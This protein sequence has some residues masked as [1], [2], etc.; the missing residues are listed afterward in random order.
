MITTFT[1]RSLM[2]LVISILMVN[3]DEMQVP[4]QPRLLN[5]KSNYKAGQTI[6]L[7]MRYQGKA[8]NWPLLISSSYGKVVLY[9]ELQSDTLTYTLP[10]AIATKSGLVTWTLLNTHQELEGNFRIAST[11]EAQRIET[12]LGPPSIVA[13]NRD[14]SMQI[15]QPV[16]RFDN[17]LEDSVLVQ[18][19]HRFLEQ[20]TVDSIALQHSIA[21]KRIY[22]PTQT[23]RILASSAMNGLTTAEYSIDVLPGLPTDFEVS[24]N[25]I[26]PYADGNQICNL[27]TSVIVDSFKNPVADGT[28]VNFV[29]KNEKNEYL[30]TF[31]STI[32]GVAQASMIHPEYASTWTLTA[33]VD[34]MAQ[35][36][37][38][39]INFTAAVS[40]FQISS[41][42]KNQ[43]VVGPIRSFMN[44]LIPDGYSVQLFRS[45]KQT[46]ELIENGYTRKGYAYFDLPP[47]GENNEDKH[48]II[49]AGGIR[50]K[51]RVQ[52][53]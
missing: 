46:D 11:G 39:E 12:F 23:G 7:R 45:N 28:L 35:S 48:F 49:Q 36:N 10:K 42:N 27:R 1:Y 40:D 3:Q 16:D 52:H 37:S 9:P 33:F 8:A 43:I 50:K 31:G 20:Y 29:L 17:P 30:S 25:R 5:P 32:K 18:M 15:S 34:G 21:Y 2:V 51:H 14:F 44:Q 24:F 22:S 6:Q 19:N 4:E 13:G 47:S 53:E 26:H 41:T 38:E